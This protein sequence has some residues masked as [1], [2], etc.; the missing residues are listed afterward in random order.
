[1]TFD[2]TGKRVVANQLT[3]FRDLVLRT[4][5]IG[6][7]P[8]EEAAALLAREI[9]A[10]RFRLT[11]WTSAVDQWISRLNGLTRWCPEPG[12]SAIGEAD[13]SFLIQQVCLG[14]FS[15]KEIADKPVW[16]V[17]K[18]W[19]MPGQEELIDTY[20]PERLQLPCGRKA[21]I[22]YAEDTPPILSA[23]IQDLYDLDQTPAIAMGRQPLVVEILAPN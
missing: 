7:P 19:L 5:R 2:A 13:R 14:S 1:V 16:P 20:A 12:L 21:R 11:H 4:K 23:R 22:R 10:G 17:L 8:E 15:A 6:A 9:L 3:L 18:D